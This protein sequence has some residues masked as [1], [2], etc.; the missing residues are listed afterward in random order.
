MRTSVTFRRIWSWAIPIAAALVGLA[1]ITTQGVLTTA[2][3]AQ[4]GFATVPRAEC[5]PDDRAET[6]AARLATY[7]AQTAP[8]VDYYR[9]QGILREIDGTGD[10]D[11]IYARIR[12]VLG[13]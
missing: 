13:A 8:V 6:I 1:V 4:D 5:G 7:A 2:A 10:L 3:Y 12:G 11:V 9:A